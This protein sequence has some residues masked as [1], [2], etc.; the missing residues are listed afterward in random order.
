MR[1]RNLGHAR[2]RQRKYLKKYYATGFTHK[3]SRKGEPLCGES[4]SH[5]D[6]GFEFIEAHPVQH[7]KHGTPYTPDILHC[8]PEE[9]A[10]PHCGQQ[11]RS[12]V[13]LFGD[14]FWETK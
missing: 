10:C 12:V 5:K 9:V 4:F 2:A 1:P 11:V 8:E 7:S 13:T 3:P 14:E 6:V